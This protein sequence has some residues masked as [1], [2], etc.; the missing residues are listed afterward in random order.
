MLQNSILEGPNFQKFLGGMPSD[1]LVLV[2]FACKCAL[3]TIEIYVLVIKLH[4]YS[5]FSTDL[6]LK[7]LIQPDH[8]KTRGTSPGS[9]VVT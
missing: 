9:Y 8:L 5:P 2:C 6:I 1:S 3:H 7:V 4:N